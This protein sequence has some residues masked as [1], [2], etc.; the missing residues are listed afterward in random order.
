[1]SAFDI[2]SPRLQL[3]RRSLFPEDRHPN[4]KTFL[5]LLLHTHQ[6]A[7]RSWCAGTAADGWDTSSRILNVQRTTSSVEAA[8]IFTTFQKCAASFANL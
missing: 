5:R 1:V 7:I 6:G 2:Q 3:L 8:E 4:R